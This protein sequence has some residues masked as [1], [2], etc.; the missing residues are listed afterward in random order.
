ME[1]DLTVSKTDSQI[2]FTE[3]AADQ[4]NQRLFYIPIQ[5]TCGGT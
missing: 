3:R 2:T 5:G 4:I 1:K